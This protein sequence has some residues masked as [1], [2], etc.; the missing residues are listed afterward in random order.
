VYSMEGKRIEEKLLRKVLHDWPLE[1]HG[2]LANMKCTSI[3]MGGPIPQ[4][5]P[6]A[7]VP[8]PVHQPPLSHAT[9]NTTA[10]SPVPS[11]L[12]LTEETSSPP[13][14]VD[15]DEPLPPTTASTSK[16]LNWTFDFQDERRGRKSVERWSDDIWDEPYEHNPYKKKKK[17]VTDDKPTIKKEKYPTQKSIYDPESDDEDELNLEEFNLWYDEHPDQELLELYR[18]NVQRVERMT[19]EEEPPRM[20]LEE[21]PPPPPPSSSTTS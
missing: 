7:A 13:V 19:L 1:Q 5:R 4:L 11:S 9:P 3:S 12:P 16:V 17:V 18:S 14:D 21:E 2:Y 8:P 10:S 15:I 20:T 6:P